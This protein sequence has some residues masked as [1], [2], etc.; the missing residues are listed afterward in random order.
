[1]T[2]QMRAIALACCVTLA[3]CSLPPRDSG[4]QS[5]DPAARLDALRTAVAEND[6]SAV[7]HLISML[8]SDDPALRMFAQHGLQRLTDRSFGYD[9]AAPPEQRRRATDAWAAWWQS[10]STS[11]P[12]PNPETGG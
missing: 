3:G 6:R 8:D 11:T 5:R 7:P 12:S 1:M 9:Y 10:E 2:P 4:F